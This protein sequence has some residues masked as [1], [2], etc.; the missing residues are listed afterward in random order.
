MVSDEQRALWAAI[1]ANPDDDTPRLVYADWLQEHGDEDRAEFIRVQ[2]ELEKLGPDRRKGRKERGP[3]EAQLAKLAPHREVWLAPFRER[4]SGPNRRRSDNLW[5]EGAEFCRGFVNGTNC[6]LATAAAVAWAGDNLEPMDR[7]EVAEMGANY[8]H[9]KVAAIA[10]WPGAGCVTFLSLAW[11]TDAD[12]AVITRGHLSN[13]RHLGLWGGKVS[14]D[15]V[16][17][18][19][20]WPG[21]TALH[22]LNLQ[23]NPQITDAGAIALAESPHLTG[24]KRL[25]LRGIRFGADAL[26]ALRT[27]FGSALETDS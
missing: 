18:L 14:D 2:C 26:A 11:A 17:Q 5:T 15:G 20:A 9:P 27:R 25:N 10:A 1:R 8:D 23:D 4:L 24:I 13:L 22:S 16:E 6:D 19:A 3:L 7:I 12:P 21:A